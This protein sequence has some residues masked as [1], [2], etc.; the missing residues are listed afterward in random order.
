MSREE[1]ANGESAVARFRDG[2][3]FFL[4][5]LREPARLG[6][7]LPH[8]RRIA[9][10]VAAELREHSP[11]RVV[12]LGAGT[13]ALTRAILGVLPP[14][15]RLLCIERDEGFCRRLGELFVDRVV[16]VQADAL[17]IARVIAGS[18]WEEPD[19]LVCSVP[20]LGGV[21]MELCRNIAAVLPDDSLFVQVSN[22]RGPVE[23]FFDIHKTRLFM[24]NIPPEQV[25]CGFPKGG[26]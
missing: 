5:F 8:N 11:Q 19:A 25:H 3:A 24:S 9:A 1:G 4:R 20:L 7:P 10:A 13:G 23:A 15:E 6:V 22:V 16:V 2:L 14:P 12:E 18:P 21:G 17:D 26:P